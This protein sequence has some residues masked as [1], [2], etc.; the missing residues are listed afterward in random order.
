LAPHFASVIH[1]LTVSALSPANENELT[2]T[3]RQIIKHSENAFF[4]ELPP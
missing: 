4:I 2:E 3:T 1:P